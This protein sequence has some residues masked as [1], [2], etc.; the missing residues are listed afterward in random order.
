M[1]LS[2]CLCAENN[3]QGRFELFRLMAALAICILQTLMLYQQGVKIGSCAEA[4]VSRKRHLAK[5]I[6][7]QL[8]LRADGMRMRVRSA[9]TRPSLYQQLCHTKPKLPNEVRLIHL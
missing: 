5:L 3:F 8:E 1:A 7:K 4:C 9:L 6:G 2:V